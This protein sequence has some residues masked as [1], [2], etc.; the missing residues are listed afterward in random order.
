MAECEYFLNDLLGGLERLE[1]LAENELYYDSLA[2]IR[3]KM[4]EGY[5][6]DG[7]FDGAIDTYDKII[8]EN[9]GADAAAVAYYGL[10]LI[11][12]YD[13]ED[14]EKA[15][16]F[17]QKARE[18]K[19]NSSISQDATRRASKLAMLERYSKSGSI[20]LEA[21]S[22]GE[23]DQELLD[24]LTENQFMLGELF[25]F[26]LEK[27]DSAVQAFSVLLERYPES[28]FAPRALMSMAFIHRT[29]FADTAGADSL[30]REVLNQYQRSDE[31][32]EVIG[33]LGL[34]GTIA[35]TGYASITY[36]IAEKYLEQFI[37]L[38]S[39]MYYMILVADSIIVADSIRREDST[40][41]YDS[42]QR[43]DSL[44]RAEFPQAA[45]S[46]QVSDSM[47]VEDIELAVDTTPP[48]VMDP[49]SIRRADSIRIAD[50]IKYVDARRMADSIRE[51]YMNPTPIPPRVADSIRIADSLKAMAL[52][53]Q[54]DSARAADSILA[55]DSILA[56]DSA[57]IP[58][59]GPAIDSQATPDALAAIDSLAVPDSITEEEPAV[60]SPAID[61]QTV[62]DALAAIDSLA[63]PDSVLEEEP[64]VSGPV[65]DSQTVPDALAAIDSSAAPDSITEEEPA[66]SSPAIDSQTVPDALAAIDSLVV[67]DSLLEEDAVVSSPVIDSQT[68]PDALATIDSL[69]VP[70][71]TQMTDS[72]TIAD[73]TL[74]I[75][76]TTESDSTLAIDTI[77]VSDSLWA[78]DSLSV[79][80]SLSKVDTSAVS[81]TTLTID[82]LPASDTLLTSD[83]TIVHDSTLT[84]DSLTETDTL[85]ITDTA[86]T[87]IEEPKIDY[88][89]VAFDSAPEKYDSVLYDL[90]DSA[91]HYYHLV[92][93]SFPLSKY[94]VQA[95]YV[96]LWM[97]DKYLAPGDS[98]LIDLYAAFVDSFPE[99][100]YTGIIT[101]E[102]NIRPR[103]GRPK[104]QLDDL[105]QQQ[106]EQDI[107]SSQF[108]A[109][110]IPEDDTA[111]SPPL[112]SAESRF[113]TDEDGNVLE[114]AEKYFLREEVPFRYPLEALA[115]NIEDKLYFQIRIDFSGEVAEVLLMN[116]TE[117]SELNERIIE[118]IKF[119]RFDAGRI[120]PEL[121]DHWFYYTYTVRIP[122]DMRQ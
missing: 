104:R 72:L 86:E 48:V 122:A 101:E 32:E 66:A 34:A 69:V 20:S 31:A 60:S 8:I 27:P 103:G 77:S 82:S 43:I 67:P 4:A 65:I 114:P 57:A 73:S 62:P 95:R 81:D 108:A 47:Q 10:G 110:D 50:S 63:I 6:W 102:Y 97:Y 83:S 28:R 87:I 117:S 78:R 38:D 93:D 76:S 92:I 39:S 91:Q 100:E 56:A 15:R 85:A 12:Q 26:D 105:Q 79:S 59:P 120:N 2:P 49:E 64:T 17:Y 118:T 80:D 19:R 68:V 3:L 109:Y 90:L 22:T 74:A 112:S 44:Q 7:D 107:D 1:E 51:A 88:W 71:S 106:Q 30:L 52:M 111:T 36:A 5:E 94:S 89:Q 42:L 33:M 14:L 58:D 21:D 46:L 55:G 40:L 35:D 121:Y 99:S 70:D 54:A 24:Q 16:G 75:G 11:Y 9:P 119:T 25:Y 18:E 53:R 96:L 61:S 115:Y 41:M 116:E 45:D 23:V 84:I 29:E 113:I 98:S 13:F 37:E